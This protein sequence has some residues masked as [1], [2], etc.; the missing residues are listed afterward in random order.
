M[1]KFEKILRRV[2]SGTSDANI[3][4]ED[5]CWLLQRLGFSERVRGSHHIF[6]RR[7]VEVPINL[8]PQG[9]QCKPYQIR[10]MRDLLRQAGIEEEE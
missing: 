5:A 2:L 7:D 3:S 1:C 6:E 4:F 8:Q 9:A 10:Q